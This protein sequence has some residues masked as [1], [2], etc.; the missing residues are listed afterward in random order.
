VTRA[1]KG[2]GGGYGFVRCDGCGVQRYLHL[3]GGTCRGFVPPRPP[4]LVRGL[5][6]AFALALTGVGRFLYRYPEGK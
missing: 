2:Y 1:A 5:D 3:S 4:A 6:R